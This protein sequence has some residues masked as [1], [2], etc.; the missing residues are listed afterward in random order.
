MTKKL[1]TSSIVNELQS[2]AFFRR[3]APEREQPKASKPV[4][5]RNR[6]AQSTRII[7]Q[8]N[9]LKQSTKAIDRS[10][11]SKRSTKAVDQSNRPAQSTTRGDQLSKLGQLVGSVKKGSPSA[12]Y[13]PKVISD[14][15]D[16]AVRFYRKK[17][18]ISQVDRTAIV[19]A[20]LGDPKLWQTESLDHMTEKV[21]EQFNDRKLR[22][23]KARL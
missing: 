20:I 8:D 16:E 5:Q 13:L 21:I 15:I 12:F 11:R 10:S 17:K 7:D 1:N 6:P 22:R 18:K 3:P 4:D 14:K 19:A 9:R 2:S 23:L